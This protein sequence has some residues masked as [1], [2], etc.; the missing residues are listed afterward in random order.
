MV[1]LL[2]HRGITEI[3]KSVAEETRVRIIHILSFAT[4]SV[5]ELT[6]ILEMG[7]SRVSRH[8]KI[9]TDAG[10]LTFQRE[11]SWVY[12]RLA[13][14]EGAPAELTRLLLSWKE[15]L[16]AREHDQRKAAEILASREEKSNIYFNQVGQDWENLQK[17]VL[18]PDNYRDRIMAA[19][20][21]N[22]DLVLDAG[23][24]Q[25]L[26]IPYLLSKAKNVVGLD[27]SSK[28][29]ELARASFGNNPDVSFHQA[30]LEQIPLADGSVDGLVV[31]M[32]LH[33]A[34]NP[35]F[36][37]NELNRVLRD[38]GTICLVDLKKHNQEYMREKFADFWLGFDREMLAEW[39]S[40]S[41]FDL[42]ESEE[43][44]T[45][46]LFNILM[47]K[48]VKRRTYVRNKN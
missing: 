18:N 44:R 26:L 15:D 34:S 23:C 2:V 1:R 31:S 19:L 5:N 47:I 48:A 45:K 4:F 3:L 28:M 38:E 25:G 14:E 21:D 36:A 27:L 10:I 12:Y 29:I 22:M 20:P 16:P 17:E 35:P 42:V 33:H 37:L 40:H 41:G 32:V 13:E 8:L 6:E 7:Q 39:L 30:S 11:G 46:S 9:L 24:G 43:I